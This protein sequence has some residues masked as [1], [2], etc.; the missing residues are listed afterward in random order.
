M[1]ARDVTLTLA[2]SNIDAKG[3]LFEPTKS[4]SPSK[5]GTCPTCPAP[6]V[7]CPA[8]PCGVTRPV[9]VADARA[10]SPRFLPMAARDVT[11]TLAGSNIDAKG[12]LFEPRRAASRP[13]R[14]PAKGAPA[15]PA[16]RRR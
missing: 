4:A 11:L 10:D 6:P 12:T 9:S 7:N 3:T 1:A 5:R 2:G 16:L 14:R 8:I 13:P 15:P